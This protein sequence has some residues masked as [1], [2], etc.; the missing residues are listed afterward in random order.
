MIRA[1]RVAAFDQGGSISEEQHHPNTR[2]SL[3]AEMQFE[4]QP[5]QAQFIQGP[6]HIH[7]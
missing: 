6:T 7:K 4:L 1:T 5:F 3:R 2:E